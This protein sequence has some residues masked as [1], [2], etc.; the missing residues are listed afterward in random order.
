[1]LGWSL[2]TALGGYA[3]AIVYALVAAAIALAAWWLY[4]FGYD[5]AEALWT[6]KYAKR[7]AEIS[8]L[9]SAELN[10]VQQANAIAKELERKRLEKI[11]AENAAL[12]KRIKELS[13]EADADP[14]R[15]R[16]CLSDGGRLRIDEIR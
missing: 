16:V 11:E 6:A 2:K 3:S 12:E 15:D 7:E 8:Q 1:M 5:R 10:R 9:V 4:G 13:D 14:D